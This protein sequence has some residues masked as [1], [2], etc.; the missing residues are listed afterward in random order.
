MIVIQTFQD[1]F[2]LNCAAIAAW[3]HHNTISSSSFEKN[4]G[5]EKVRVFFQAHVVN[6]RGKNCCYG[7]VSL[8]KL[9]SRT[10]W[11]D[12]IGP[13]LAS[14]AAWWLEGAESEQNNDCAVIWSRSTS[15]TSD[16]LYFLLMLT[17][18]SKINLC[19]G[20]LMFCQRGSFLSLTATLNFVEYWSYWLS[21][22]L[23]NWQTMNQTQQ[24]LH[25]RSEASSVTVRFQSAV[26]H[27]K[28][29][30]WSEVR[31]EKERKAPFRVWWWGLRSGVAPPEQLSHFSEHWLWLWLWLW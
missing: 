24:A 22:N 5:G 10:N 3:R 13:D 1:S 20:T 2:L 21:K 15:S 11:A 14:V 12:L 17:E 8:T 6:Q 30:A 18:L 4:E 7:D 29:G 26:S 31:W 28:N 25:S 23:L 19:P 16:F 9:I 27:C